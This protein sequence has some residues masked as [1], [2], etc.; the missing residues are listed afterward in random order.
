MHFCKMFP[1]YRKYTNNQSFFKIIDL[2]IFEEIMLIGKFYTVNRYEINDFVTRNFLND[3]IHLSA[4]GIVNS[5]EKEY[6]EQL[7]RCEKN[8]KRL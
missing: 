3:L 1:L 2:N 6:A 7:L 8:L 4:E 5:S